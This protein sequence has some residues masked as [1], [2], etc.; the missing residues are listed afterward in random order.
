M[1][2]IR[3]A[4]RVGKPSLHVTTCWLFVLPLEIPPLPAKHRQSVFGFRAL[5]WQGFDALD[6]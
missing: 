4:A 2:S 6:Q 3:F 5:S 1:L